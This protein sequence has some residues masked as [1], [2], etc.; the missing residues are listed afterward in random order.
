MNADLNT[1]N[2]ENSER[3]GVA[4]RSPAATSCLCCVDMQ[5]IPDL[6]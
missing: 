3:A 6:D 4:R 5:V 2:P 1:L